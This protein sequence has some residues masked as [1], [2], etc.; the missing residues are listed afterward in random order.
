M[1]RNGDARYPRVELSLFLVHGV[2]KLMKGA[3]QWSILHPVTCGACHAVFQPGSSTL[4]KP[5]VS[6]TAKGR[7]SLPRDELHRSS[8]V[9]TLRCDTSTKA[10]VVAE[11]AADQCCAVS[12]SAQSGEPTGSGWDT[13]GCKVLTSRALVA[14]CQQYTAATCA[15][16][17]GIEAITAKLIDETGFGRS[18]RRHNSHCVRRRTDTAVIEASTIRWLGGSGCAGEV[19]WL[20]CAHVARRSVRG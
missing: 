20:Q 1:S 5:F 14:K 19:S 9:L 16:T 11:Q 15:V 17:S 10:V 8:A 4:V 12:R 7:R 3:L 18:E 13:K 6:F 2:A